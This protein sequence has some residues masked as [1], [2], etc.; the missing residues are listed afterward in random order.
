MENVLDVTKLPPKLK[1]WQPSRT[2]LS[3]TRTINPVDRQEYLYGYG[4]RSYR[5]NNAVAYM[6]TNYLA[7]SRDMRKAGIV[8]RECNK[9]VERQDKRSLLCGSL[10]TVVENGHERLMQEIDVPPDQFRYEFSHSVNISAP[11]RNVAKPI[12]EFLHYRYSVFIT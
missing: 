4:R 5:G 10:P 2:D 7:S 1:D 6:N 8:E 12:S 9:T 3:R 11:V